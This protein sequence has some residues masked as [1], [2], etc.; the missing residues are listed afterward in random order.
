[1]VDHDLSLGNIPIWHDE[2]YLNKYLSTE[3]CKALPSVF[4]WPEA[5]KADRVPYVLHLEKK[6]QV[7]RQSF[8]QKLNIEGLIAGDDSNAELEIYKKLYLNTHEKC[9]RLEN[10]LVQKNIGLSNIR[11]WISYFKNSTKKP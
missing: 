9:Q 8:D 6:H 10:R 4:A 7:I 5:E 2:S 11:E 3:L 1:M